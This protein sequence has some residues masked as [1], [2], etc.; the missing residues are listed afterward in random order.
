MK[1]KRR[2]IYNIIWIYRNFKLVKKKKKMFSKEEN[3]KKKEKKKKKQKYN[4]MSR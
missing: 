4:T 2:S 1:M 3:K